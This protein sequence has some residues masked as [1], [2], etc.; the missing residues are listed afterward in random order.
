MGI[1]LTDSEF[2]FDDT[3]S[4]WYV[5]MTSIHTEKCY[6]LVSAMKCLPDDCMQLVTGSYNS[7]FVL[8]GLI[9][10]KKI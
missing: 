4:R 6:H 5:V 9:K 10:F 2:R 3:L 7:T 8:V 1:G